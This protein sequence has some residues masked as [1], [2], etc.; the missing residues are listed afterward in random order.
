MEYMLAAFTNTRGTGGGPTPAA[1]PVPASTP[2]T[3]APAIAASTPAP[4]SATPGAA[5]PAATGQ[6]QQQQELPG[7]TP[8]TQAQASSAPTPSVA[9]PL[10]VA[11]L[12]FGGPSGI[13]G[14]G[15]P[16]RGS[17]CVGGRGL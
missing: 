16:V 15:A 4:S 7:A 10:P 5:T 12:G 13:K 11:A 6:Q 1:Q 9:S 3:A 17:V 8:Q 2:S 14:L